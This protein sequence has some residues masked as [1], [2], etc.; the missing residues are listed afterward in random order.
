MKLAPLFREFHRSEGIAPTLVHTGQHY[1]DRMSGQFF[2]DLGL[3][4]PQFHLAV[5]SGSHAQQT[6]EIMKRFE[7]VMLEESPD[8]VLVVGDVNSTAA[9]ALVAS[10]LGCPVIHVEAGLRS[11]DR[12]MPE[13]IN[14]LVTD[15][16]SDLFLV[17]EESALHNLEREGVSRE[18]VFFVGNLMIDSLH[19]H[20]PAARASDILDRLALRGRRYGLVT[21]HRP[22]NVDDP[23]QLGEILGAL[24]EISRELPL[25]FPVHPRTRSLLPPRTASPNLQLSDPLGYLDFLGLLSN[26]TVVLTDSG[27]IQEETTALG[28]PCLTLRNNT[29]RPI[30][31]EQGTN[32]LAGNTRESILQTWSDVRDTPP[33][34]TPPPL[35]WDG[36]AAERCVAAILQ[37]F[38]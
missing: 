5:G 17:T 4:E 3:P 19:F 25:L 7:S 16:I 36:R 23:R 15:A 14:R 28:I 34:T 38:S 24:D 32:R 9:C 6:A 18:K 33:G 21:L 1:D 12:S 20:L 2:R 10:K 29:E 37:R 13:E 35:Y 30:T 11:F 8:A 26:S 22:A 27:G 31:V